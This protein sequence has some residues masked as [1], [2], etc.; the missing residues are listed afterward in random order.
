MFDVLDSIIMTKLDVLQAS[1]TDVENDYYIDE[2]YECGCEGSCS[3]NCPG[4]CTGD[5]SGNCSWVKGGL[6]HE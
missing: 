3:G 2:A 1:L 4:D 6:G 5:C